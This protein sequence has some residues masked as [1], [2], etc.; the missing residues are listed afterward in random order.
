MTVLASSVRLRSSPANSELPRA[1][2][3]GQTLLDG[4]PVGFCRW[5]R[6][7]LW[8]D[9]HQLDPALTE[10]KSPAELDEKQR[11]GGTG[12]AYRLIDSWGDR[13]A[14]GERLWRYVCREC[15]ASGVWRPDY[16]SA[17]ADGE[18]HRLGVPENSCWVYTDTRRR[19]SKVRTPPRSAYGDHTNDRWQHNDRH[20]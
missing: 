4:M 13:P 7:D 5:C 20:T 3:D 6:T 8:C 15:D 2:I 17:R 10:I 12:H 1:E 19:W 14:T 18:E 11:T 9:Y 16:P